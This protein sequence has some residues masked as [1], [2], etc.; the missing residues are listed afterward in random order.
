MGEPSYSTY[1]VGDSIVCSVSA[2]IFGHAHTANRAGAL[3]STTNEAVMLPLRSVG[4]L[5]QT[6]FYATVANGEP[7]HN[8]LEIPGA[9]TTLYAD[10]RCRYSEAPSPGLVYRLLLV[11]EEGKPNGSWSKFVGSSCSDRA[12]GPPHSRTRPGQN[13]MMLLAVEKRST[14]RLNPKP[15]R[16]PLVQ[17]S[18]P[19]GIVR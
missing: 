13:K 3:E 15:V 9:F 5:G 1:S 7:G 19:A 6:T 12:G 14:D 16:R 11:D 2:A 17:G 8:C 18:R 10:G 4:T